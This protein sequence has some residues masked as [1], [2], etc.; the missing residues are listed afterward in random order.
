[1]IVVE[2][3]D[4]QLPSRVIFASHRT[5][6]DNVSALA[7]KRSMADAARIPRYDFEKQISLIGDKP[8][9]EGSQICKYCIRHKVGTGTY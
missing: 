3:T 8:A 6:L 9:S 4:L 7:I 2:H 1:M 5:R